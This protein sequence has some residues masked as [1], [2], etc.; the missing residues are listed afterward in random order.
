MGGGGG[1]L[2]ILKSLKGGIDG[3]GKER[4]S[5]LVLFL[6]FLLFLTVLCISLCLHRGASMRGL[7]LWM[8]VCMCMRDNVS[9]ALHGVK[10]SCMF[11]IKV[12]V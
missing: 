4:F 3:E 7:S 5:F 1:A 2:K 11:W 8:S 9:V 12:H 10:A 6:V